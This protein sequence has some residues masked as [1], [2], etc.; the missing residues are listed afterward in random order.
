MDKRDSE[1]HLVSLSELKKLAGELVTSI[2]SIDVETLPE[3]AKEQIKDAME[4]NNRFFVRMNGYIRMVYNDL[5]EN[6]QELMASSNEIFEKVSRQLQKVTE[7]TQT[8][9]TRVMDRTDRICEKQNEIFDKL[10]AIK[11]KLAA[12]GDDGDIKEVLAVVE[13]TE[14]VEQDI[15]MEVFEIMNEMQFQDITTQQLQQA[16]SLIMEA[17]KRLNEFREIIS[18]VAAGSE[19]NIANVRET[20]DPSASMNGREE[21]QSLADSIVTQFKGKY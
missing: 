2:D 16:N 10:A 19:K 20:F 11:E 15:Q 13:E 6:R 7:S 18:E 4:N 14:A 1:K 8:V 21:R 12:R 9:A 17:E 3:D 5:E